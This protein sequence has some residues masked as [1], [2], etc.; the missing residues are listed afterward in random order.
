MTTKKKNDTPSTKKEP[1]F[2][3]REVYNEIRKT[4]FLNDYRPG[5]KLEYRKMAENMGMSP[6]PVVQALKHMELL[7][8]VRHEPNRGFF[9]TEISQ[10]EIKEAYRLREILELSLVPDIIA[11]LD[12]SGEKK[13]K[14]T[15][16]E[17]IEASKKGHVKLQMAKDFKFHLTIAEISGQS[18]TLWILRYLFDFLYLNRYRRGLFFYRPDNAAGNEHQA[19]FDAVMARDTG[20]ARSAIKKHIRNICSDTLEVMKS[21]TLDADQIDF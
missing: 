2:L 16:H 13:L 10:E 1:K 6:T 11:N 9:I 20:A 14:Q 8:L 5:Q 7:E 3:T 19:I 17:Y 4:I 15:L 18:L 21:Q 12:D